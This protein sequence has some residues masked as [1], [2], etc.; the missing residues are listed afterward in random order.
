MRHIDSSSKVYSGLLLIS[1]VGWFDLVFL[2]TRSH[3]VQ[4]ALELLIS[5]PSPPKCGCSHG[6]HAH[7]VI[8]RKKYRI[9]EKSSAMNVCQKPLQLR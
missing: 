2:E 1:W 7:T 4:A 6:H 5:L 8:N 3:E 9:K